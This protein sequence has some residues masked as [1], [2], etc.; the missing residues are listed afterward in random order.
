M[1]ER[2]TIALDVD[3]VLA[4]FITPTLDHINRVT[5]NTYVKE[6]VKDFNIWS[7]LGLDRSQRY[8]ST[9]PLCQEGFCSNLLPIEGTQGLVAYLQKHFRVLAITTPWR[10]SPTWAFERTKWLNS[11]FNI[12][13]NDIV[14]CR[15]K[16]LIISDFF[17]DDNPYNILESSAVSPV[18]MDQ[19]WNRDFVSLPRAV[20][21]DNFVHFVMKNK[22]NK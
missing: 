10:A 17:L 2:K 4:D 16:S 21:F 6:D 7:S 12:T 1:K 8:L 3:G 22:E 14:F 15:D 18:L 19:P 13:D 11:Y 5:R 20:S 9:L